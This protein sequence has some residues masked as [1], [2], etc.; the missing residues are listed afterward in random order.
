[1]PDR[2]AAAGAIVD[3]VRRRVGD[4]LREQIDAAPAGPSSAALL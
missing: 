1:M 2:D 4:V 3:N